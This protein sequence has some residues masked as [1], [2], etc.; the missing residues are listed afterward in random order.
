MED[1]VK[2]LR[3]RLD[4][5]QAEFGSRIG[6]APNTISTYE[7]G[8]R[9]LSDAII[10][11]ICREFGVNET[12]LRTSAGEMFRPRTREQELGEGIRRI[13]VDRPD[14]F[15]AAL[16]TVLLRFD[17]DGPEWA[18][19]ERIAEALAAETKKDPEA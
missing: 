12:W 11:S 18:A 10:K 4:L 9:A 2:E 1:R 14:G 16:L 3:K 17:P 5:S 15:Q 6:V 8:S 13:L 7:N 19:L